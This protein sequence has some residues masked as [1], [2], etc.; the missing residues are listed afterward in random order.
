MQPP[1]MSYN[2]YALSSHRLVSPEGSVISHD[3]TGI[4]LM[5]SP[6]PY[7]PVSLL[8]MHTPPRVYRHQG[9]RAV[10]ASGPLSSSPTWG[11]GGLTGITLLCPTY[12][13]DL[14]IFP[15]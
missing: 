5:L 8:L 7:L 15:T 3:A 6:S 9:V 4:Q 2:H 12:C 10:A 11:R 13:L 14:F 1:H